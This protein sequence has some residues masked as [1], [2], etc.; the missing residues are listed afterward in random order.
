MSLTSI[1][2]GKEFK[3][4]REKFAY[5]FL[6]PAF[7]IKTELKAPP[8][9]N[10][11]TI[12]GTAFDYLMRFYLQHLN[13]NTFVQQDMWVADEAYKEL[14]GQL[15]QTQEKKIITGFYRDKSFK[16]KDLLKLINDQ[17]SQTKNNYKKFVINGKLSDEFIANT[18]FLA[19]L[20]VYYRAGIID[21]NFDY[22]EPDDIKDIK[23][24]LSLVDHKYFIAKKKCYFNPEFGEGSTL[25]GGADADLIIDNTLI[26]IKATKH[27]KLDRQHLNQI[28]GYYILSLIGGV[29]KSPK[30]RPI[31][32]IG[33]YFARHG[34]LWTV[35]LSQFGNAQ[36]FH[37]FKDWFIKFIKR[38][39]QIPGTVYGR[40]N[41]PD[42]DQLIALLKARNWPF[43]L[44]KTSGYVVIESPHLGDFYGFSSK[45]GL[46]H[47]AK[48]MSL[49]PVEIEIHGDIT[50][51]YKAELVQSDN[52]NNIIAAQR[53]MQKKPLKK[54]KRNK[55][56]KSTPPKS[57]KLP[58]KH[59]LNG[60]LKDAYAA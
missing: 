27:L 8:L 29:N 19:K 57:K 12:V 56:K 3:E 23:A 59:Q 21:S 13:K 49:N 31:K 46:S 2:K 37:N 11:Y 41:T 9:T 6:K 38:N 48:G 58:R 14:F 28:L 52:R 4:L 35:P 34:E 16:T 54:A 33:I 47:T 44:I 43:K 1:L 18:I 20:D 30:A 53:K 51:I 25:V 32:N 60:K 10:N 36:K 7:N 26:D 15:S 5:D 24:M 22:H 39:T 45:H 17:Y 50:K 55:T 42:P 40:I